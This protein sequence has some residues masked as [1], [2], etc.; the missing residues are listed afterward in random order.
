M[1]GSDR[2]T[3]GARLGWN[4][5]VTWCS[6]PGFNA[7]R[8]CKKCH[9]RGGKYNLEHD[10]ETDAHWGLLYSCCYA[11]RRLLIAELPQHDN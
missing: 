9:S 1:L 2:T 5:N 3:A 6:Y 10:S 8:F 4:F 11:T 7:T